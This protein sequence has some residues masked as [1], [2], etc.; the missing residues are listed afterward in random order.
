M[1]KQEYNLWVEMFDSLVELMDK[2]RRGKD[3]KM[4]DAYA[5]LVHECWNTL[6]NKE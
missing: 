3:A 2:A 4:L 1:T 6:R 5:R